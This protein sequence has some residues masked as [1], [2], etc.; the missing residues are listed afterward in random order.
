MPGVGTESGGKLRREARLTTCRRH[1]ACYRN[2]NF[3]RDL[4]ER[5]VSGAAS[6]SCAMRIC[7]STAR[8]PAAATAFATSRIEAGGVSRLP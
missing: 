3:A 8:R 4:I 2:T 7:Q 1:V 6:Q 5:E